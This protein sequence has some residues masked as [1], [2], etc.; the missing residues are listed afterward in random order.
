[1]YCWTSPTNTVKRDTSS[2]RLIYIVEN[3]LWQ[4]KRWLSKH[5]DSYYQPQRSKVENSVK[6]VYSV[7]PHES[8]LP[9]NMKPEVIYLVRT[10]YTCVSL[11]VGQ[12]SLLQHN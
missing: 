6:S 1:M 3:L 5:W 8:S 12:L 10:V 9:Y 7:Q 11:I 2:E 4:H